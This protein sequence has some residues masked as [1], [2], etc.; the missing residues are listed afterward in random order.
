MGERFGK[1]KN[2]ND[3]DEIF[4]QKTNSKTFSAIFLRH[5]ALKRYR[6][7]PPWIFLYELNPSQ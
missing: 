6:R 3:E 2:V 1:G 7:R 5:R 4:L